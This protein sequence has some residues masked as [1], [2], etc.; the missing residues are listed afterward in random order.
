MRTF[1]QWAL[2]LAIPAVW[3]GTS[4]AAD[5]EAEMAPEG[6]TIQLLLLRQKSVRR[7]LGL[8]H[9][10]TSKIFEFTAKQYD[11]ARAAVKLG[12]DERRQKFEALKR[13]N[14]E[15][16][17]ENLTP[18]QRKRL[19]QITLQVVGLLWMTQPAI[20]KEL[21]LTDEQR[22]KAKELREHTR[23]EARDL[24]RSPSGPERRE[25]YVKFREETRRKLQQLLT[26]DQRAKWKELVGRP[27]K[28]LIEYE[29]AGEG[30][31]D[32]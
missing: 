15:F 28:G 14:E 21:N 10:H 3:V 12:Q 13:Q 26:K 19:D 17:K 24:F 6:T 32:K 31:K 1:S 11:T 16:L 30:G 29:E 25:K 8:T 4:W 18:E 7:D 27:F 23:Q 5:E 9:E 2:V 20:D 22:Q